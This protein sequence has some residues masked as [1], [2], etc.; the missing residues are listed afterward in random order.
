[1]VEVSDLTFFQE[2][3]DKATYEIFVTDAVGDVLYVND[4]TSKLYGMNPEEIIGKNMKELEETLFFPSATLQVI[5]TG[6][7]V[8]MMQKT[9]H[10]KRLFVQ[11]IPVFSEE[12]KL[13]KVV[14][15]TRELINMLTLTKQ[16]NLL[17]NQLKEKSKEQQDPSF[18]KYITNSP[19]MKQ[20]MELVLRAT[21]TD[22]PILIRGET[23][24]GKSLLAE[25][26]HYLSQ[27]NRS[28]FRQIN[29]V[30]YS[31]TVLD[32]GEELVQLMN[33]GTLYLD[34][35]DEMT[36][37][38]QSHLLNLIENK[39]I[40]ATTGMKIKQDIRFVSSAKKDLFELVQE[41]K[42]RED[43]YYR[44]NIIPIDIP[45][46]RNRKEDI[47]P[48]TMEFLQRFNQ[49]YGRSVKITSYVL[50]SFYEYE[51]S[52]N[53]R[54]L[55]NLIERLV[56]ISEKNEI[57]LGQLPSSIRYGSISKAKTLPEKMEQLERSLIIEAYDLYQSSYKVAES[58]GI[59]QSA[60]TRKIRK[61]V[62]EQQET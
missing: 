53:V 41:G 40:V 62:K 55:E 21:R 22:K 45:P 7:P 1:M 10:G 9:L 16:I 48:L 38:M 15:Y 54:E 4:I 43:L 23:G 39:E 2:L 20:M 42:F 32:N 13:I 34:N 46:L 24:V 36:L 44:L 8:E 25:R 27:R 3:A 18:Y 61:Y 47:Y 50:N 51:W 5:E 33:G 26:I 19:A 57:K 17:E 14:S 30:N 31:E 49:E 58:L 59:S 6:Q 56:I 28:L 12:G 60:A 52:G 35:I 37:E 11:S 29:C